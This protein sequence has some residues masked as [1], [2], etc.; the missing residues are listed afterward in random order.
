MALAGEGK[1]AEAARLIDPVVAMDLAMERKNRSDAWLPL[2]VAGALYAQSLA[3]PQ[4]HTALLQEAAARISHLKAAI[5]A[6][7]DTRWWQ[8]RIEASLHAAADGADR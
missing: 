3:E 7:H 6:L 4:R 8:T 5:A 2:E 1:S